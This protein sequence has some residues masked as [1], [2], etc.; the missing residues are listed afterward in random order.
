MTCHELSKALALSEGFL[1]IK[2]ISAETASS[3]KFSGCMMKALARAMTGETLV[4]AKDNL[5]CPGASRGLGLED[6]IPDMPGG[7][8]HFISYGRGKGFPPGERVKCSPEIG[9]QMMLAQPQGVMEGFNA[10][11]IK[12]YQA[13]DEADT[14]TAL[15]N[16]DQLTALIHIFCFRRTDYDCVI[17][18]MVSGCASVFRIP[19]G[20]ARN[21]RTRAVIGNA[22]VFSRPHYAAETCFFTLSGQDFRQMLL[23]AEDSVLS[24]PIWHGVQKRLVGLAKAD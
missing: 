3:Q 11:R 15:V 18:P 23:D 8:G 14:V 5:G 13:E 2:R 16:M 20:E 12:P 9:E 10:I 6:G 24:A 19:F 1:S 4:F 7:F 21:P 22:D 17:A